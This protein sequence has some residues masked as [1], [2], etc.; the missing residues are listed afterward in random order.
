M[1]RRHAHT[2]RP[3]KRAETILSPQLLTSIQ[4]RSYLPAYF[5]VCVEQVG[6]SLV[7]TPRPAQS[8]SPVSNR[9]EKSN[10]RAIRPIVY[11]RSQFITLKT[12]YWP[13]CKEFNN[14]TSKTTDLLLNCCHFHSFRT[15]GNVAATA[16][17]RNNT[18]ARRRVD[19]PNPTSRPFSPDQCGRVHWK[20]N[21]L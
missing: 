11:Q 13:C 14:V 12:G 18:L 15:T 3:H 9:S 1:R 10:F 6:A 21:M 19:V 7:R 2:V 8:S 4:S 16:A 17:S 20:R 5:P